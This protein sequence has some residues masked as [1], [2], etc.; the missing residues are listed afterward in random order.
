MTKKKIAHRIKYQNETIWFLKELKDGFMMGFPKVNP[1][2]HLTWIFEQDRF[3]IH[4]TKEG[5]NIENRYQKDLRFEG[6]FGNEIFEQLN[7]VDWMKFITER[8]ISNLP[9]K[10]YLG[11][12]FYTLTDDQTLQKSELSLED[13]MSKIYIVK[14]KHLHLCR[15]KMWFVL[16]KGKGRNGT[17][18][19]IGFLYGPLENRTFYLSYESL[20]EVFGS[21]MKIFRV[22]NIFGEC[23]A[24]K[25]TGVMFNLIKKDKNLLMRNGKRMVRLN[26]VYN[27]YPHTVPL[28][29]RQ[30]QL[31]TQP[32]EPF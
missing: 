17:W 7:Q 20:N 16:D 18:Y 23:L 31:E 6:A 1:L 5:D 22:D 32:D 12:Y 8:N 27:G 9:G 21:V 30:S 29:Y 4:S 3:T 13:L 28:A 19:D 24:V 15:E 25:K 11:G 2:S 10:A 14:R 26:R